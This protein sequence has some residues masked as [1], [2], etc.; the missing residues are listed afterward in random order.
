MNHT[1]QSSLMAIALLASVAATPAHATCLPKDGPTTLQTVGLV[2]GGTA[3]M[4]TAVA[5]PV[6]ATPIA[7]SL[8]AYQM[9][10]QPDN[11]H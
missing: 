3:L 9:V 1:F 11:C 6:V 5:V 7:V 10:L 2:L 4:I 8:A